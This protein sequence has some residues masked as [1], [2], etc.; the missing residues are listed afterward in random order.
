MKKTYMKPEMLLVELKLEQMIALS[1]FEGEADPGSP[2]LSRE[3]DV[4]DINE[5][6][7]PE[8]LPSMP[9]LF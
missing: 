3:P 9:P 5:G 1:A 7:L 8:V 4:F 2:T 6:V